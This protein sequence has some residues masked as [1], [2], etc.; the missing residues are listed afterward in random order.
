MLVTA[1]APRLGYDAAARVAR[2]AE[3]RGTTLREAAVALG[4]TTPEEFDALCRPE[5]MTRPGR[6]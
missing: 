3:A 4:V 2:E 1:L 6:P 5:A